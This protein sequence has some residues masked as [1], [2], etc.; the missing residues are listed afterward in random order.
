ML[1]GGL[2]SISFR[3]LPPEEI[4]S[5]TAGARLSCIEWGGDVH[6]PHG[7]VRRA[8]EVAA[9]T[10]GA[11]LRTSAYGSYYRLAEENEFGFED[12]VASAKA[13]GAPTIRVWAG[14]RGSAEA[15]AGYRE[16]VVAES[17]R[18]ADI[19]ARAGLTLS[20]EYHGN[21]LTDTNESALTL[22]REVDH[23][24]LR[25]FWQPPNGRDT[26]YRLEGLKAV[27][28]WMTNVHIFTWDDEN[29]RLPLADGEEWW[30][31][32]LA[33]AATT[34]RDH[35]VLMEFV[36]DDDPDNFRRDAEALKAWLDRAN[37]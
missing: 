14:R 35:D 23:E 2:V 18:C 25:S 34:G 15:D 20:Y 3:E 7:D 22:I 36:A 12:V 6:C 17:R 29:R 1:N 37:G 33:E 27:K 28:P 30:T 11:G 31:R 32:F 24:A 16:R 26:E 21:T 4:V 9:L 19:A 13:L 8:G 10:A 5:L